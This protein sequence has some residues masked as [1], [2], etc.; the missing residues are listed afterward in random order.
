MSFF[1]NEIYLKSIEKKYNLVYINFMQNILKEEK[2]K[3]LENSLVPYVIEQTSKGERSYDIFSR[4]LKDRIIF[5]SEDVNHASASL[6]VAQLLFLESED[7]DKEIYLYIN[8][9]GGSI[10]DG[11][12]IV[13][14]INYIKCPVSTVCIGMA[15][16]MGAVLLAC[17]TKGKRLATPNSEI[18]IHQPLI[19][20]GGLSGQTTE[21]KIHA[22]HMV[23]TREKLNKLLSEKTGQSLE[24]IERDTERD[25]YMTAEQALAYGLIDGILDKRN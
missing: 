25:N 10:T 22:D 9:P 6:V 2:S 17:G 20:G 24:V 5:L 18:M 3:M 11:M 4:L 19:G 7:P 13:D 14:T 1:V 12:A 8:S 21:I 15:A 16:S 23:R